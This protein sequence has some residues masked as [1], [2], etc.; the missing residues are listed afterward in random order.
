VLAAAS[1]L[2]FVRPDAL[3]PVAHV[4][5]IVGIVTAK[6]PGW[7]VIA[8]IALL[9]LPVPFFAS[10]HRHRRSAALA[11]G[12]YVAM[13]LLAPAWGTF[14]VPVMGYGASPILGYFVALAVGVGRPSQTEELWE[15]TSSR[16][17]TA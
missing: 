15:T 16:S 1:I 3:R 5:E 2:S 6:G 13:T 11:M 7:A 4:E 17:A 8:T 10:W 9:L 14:P 12:V